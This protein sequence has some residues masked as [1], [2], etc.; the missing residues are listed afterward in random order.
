MQG[1]SRI[2]AGGDRDQHVVA[3]VDRQE[4]LDVESVRRSRVVVAQEKLGLALQP[5]ALAALHVVGDEPNR[6]GFQRRLALTPPD[7]EEEIGKSVGRERGGQ[8]VEI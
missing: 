5:A 3:Q 8:Y 6:A 4:I 7:R 1:L 2:V